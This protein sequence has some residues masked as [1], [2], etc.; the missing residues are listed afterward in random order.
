[1]K[2]VI[3]GNMQA[4]AMWELTESKKKTN[5]YH[6]FQPIDQLHGAWVHV[7]DT[8]KLM[9]ATYNYLGLLNDERIN[10]AAMD[11]IHSYGT[12]THGV[13]IFGG[14]LDIHQRLEDKIAHF[15]GRQA[16][17]AYS[18]GYMTNLSTINLLL[19]RHDWIIG[20][21]L[22]HASIVDGCQLSQGTFKRFNH[23]DM[24]ELERLLYKAPK[25]VRK[26]VVADAVFSMD[27]DIFNLPDA[28]L[29]CK[30]YGAILMIDEAHSIGVLGKNCRGIEE[31]FNMENV[32]DI[33]MGT[34]SKAI[35][36]IGGYIAGDNMLINYLKHAS[37]GFVFS[38]A[39]PPAIAAA[40][41]KAIDIIENEG[42]FRRNSL[43]DNV[44]HFIKGLNEAGFYT[45]N[46]ETPIVPVIVGEDENA[47]RMTT[48]C[49]Q[50]GVLAL[51]V[52]SPGVPQGTSR[53]RLNVTANHTREDIDF[54]L[55]VIITAGKELGIIK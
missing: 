21:K 46:T 22:N 7:N 2:S 12:G 44:E 42:A 40:A 14:S 25:G 20:D 24:D 13:R 37:R 8:K 45:G 41:I 48:L 43:K 3:S 39:I 4:E 18:T 9:F 52:L 31:H 51:P 53:L 54:A 38:A 29:L 5:E 1:M 30:K 32:I 35:P 16:A 36:A 27:G 50:R 55:E 28:A 49:N 23:N 10:Q 6:Y 26:I 11:A 19:E 17:I 34:L 15:T 33:K 47:I